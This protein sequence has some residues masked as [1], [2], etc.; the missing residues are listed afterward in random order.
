MIAKQSSWGASASQP[1]TPRGYKP[2]LRACVVDCG[3]KQGATPLFVQRPDPCLHPADLSFTKIVRWLFPLRWQVPLAQSVRACRAVKTR[4]RMRASFLQPRHEALIENPNLQSA[5]STPPS[6]NS[7]SQNAHFIT[8]F[9]ST[10]SV[11]SLRHF[12]TFLGEKPGA[13]KPQIPL[14]SQAFESIPLKLDLHLIKPNRHEKIARIFS[15][16]LLENHWQIRRKVA[17]KTFKISQKNRTFSTTFHSL[18]SVVV[19]EGGVAQEDQ[20][21]RLS[22]FPQYLTQHES[23]NTSPTLLSTPCCAE[24]SGRRRVNSPNSQLCHLAFCPIVADLTRFSLISP[25]VSPCAPT[26]LN[27]NCGKLKAKNS[28][29][30]S[31]HFGGNS[32]GNQA[33]THQKMLRKCRNFRGYTAY[34][35]FPLSTLN[36]AN[37]QLAS[38]D[39]TPFPLHFQKDK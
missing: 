4:R 23:R 1:A 3:G 5:F 32:L 29:F 17:K 9:P 27:M 21:N 39:T 38:L 19:C 10:I 31:G 36:S 2:S 35:F 26:A 13:S 34:V 20:L 12:S 6:K 24:A 8:H 37:S 15:G 14:Y 7:F 25:L 16:T 30:F 11:L 22:T 18:S 28:P 33:K